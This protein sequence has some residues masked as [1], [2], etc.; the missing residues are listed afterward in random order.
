MLKTFGFQMFEI[1]CNCTLKT[2]LINTSTLLF[3]SHFVDIVIIQGFHELAFSQKVF[4]HIM[5]DYNDFQELL[6]IQ[7][8]DTKCY[9]CMKVDTFIN[10]DAFRSY[11]VGHLEFCSF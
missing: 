8:E 10:I 4:M 5:S 6:T 3:Y 9:M 11:I 2:Y 1:I 7:Y